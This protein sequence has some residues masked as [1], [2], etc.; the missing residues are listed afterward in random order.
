MKRESPERSRPIDRARA[1]V[2]WI[3]AM[4]FDGPPS[5][6]IEAALHEHGFPINGTV[7]ADNAIPRGR[8]FYLDGMS[9]EMACEVAIKTIIGATEAAESEARLVELFDVLLSK[10][11]LGDLAPIFVAANQVSLREHVSLANSQRN[12]KRSEPRSEINDLIASALDYQYQVLAI[13]ESLSE[14]G[15][16]SD[17]VIETVYESRRHSPLGYLADFPEVIS[18]LILSSERGLL[19]TFVTGFLE[20]NQTDK[21]PEWYSLA[22]ARIWRD[23]ARSVLRLLASVYP[24]LV[25][26]DIIT[27]EERL[28]IRRLAA[29]RLEENAWLASL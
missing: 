8:V 24:E 27:A 1:V 17:D 3:P 5:K 25:S 20:S 23:G 16:V 21:H 26:V 29:E 12:R 2:A 14:G 10:G 15:A 22:C 18:R 19:A 7:Y 28:D 4:P 13:V 11:A 6:Y 9:L